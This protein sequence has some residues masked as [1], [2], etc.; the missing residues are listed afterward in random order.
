V[1]CYVLN[2]KSEPGGKT[3]QKKGGK[4]IHGRH[5]LMGTWVGNAEARQKDDVKTGEGGSYPGVVSCCEEGESHG[6]L[7]SVRRM[8][9]KAAEVKGIIIIFTFRKPDSEK[10]G[11]MKGWH[12]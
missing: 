8:E 4:L 11:E 1:A 2:G 6:S 12:W 10:G 5:G 3:L 9:G 7:D